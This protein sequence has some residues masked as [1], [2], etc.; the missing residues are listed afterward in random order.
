MSTTPTTTTTTTTVAL[1]SISPT[2]AVVAGYG[3]VFGG[4]DLAGESFAA[5][6]DFQLDLV[7]RKP[8]FYD[9]TLQSEL[10]HEIGEVLRIVPDEGGLWIE[11]QLDRRKHYVAQVLELVRQGALGY[12]S[13]SVPHLVRRNGERI[14]AWPLV[15]VSLTPTPAEPRSNVQAVISMGTGSDVYKVDVHKVYEEKEKQTM[16]NGTTTSATT[17]TAGAQQVPTPATATVLAQRGSGHTPTRPTA[18]NEK[19]DT[20]TLARLEQLEQQVRGL[21]EEPAIKAGGFVVPGE[22]AGGGFRS[23]A[24]A[25]Y[26]K[27]Y[28]SYIRHGR[29]VK[30]DELEEGESAEG[31]Y[32]V[33]THYS[34]DLVAALKDASILRAAGARVISMSG[35]NSFKVPRMT[36]GNAAQQTGEEAAFDTEGPAFEEVE[37]TPWKYTRLTKVSDELLADSRI[38]IMQQVLLPDFEVAFATAENEQFT[39][40]DGTTEPQGLTVGGTTVNTTTASTFDEEDVIKLF[41]ALPYLY[42]AS[43]VWFMNDAIARQVRLFRESG[44]SGK[45]I[46]EPSFQSGQPDRL[47][48]RPVYTLNNLSDTVSTGNAIMVFCDPRFFWVV[49][50]GR[51]TLRRLDELYAAS[52][53]VG[54]RAYRRI[55]SRVMMTEAV[56][57]LTVQ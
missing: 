39:N 4:R 48:G 25:R 13:G 31:G 54:F 45:F 32:L 56:Q 55:D 11:A 26:I 44:T 37:F 7:P 43:G 2:H 16:A 23:E 30:Y 33:P 49:D 21:V 40:G 35:T 12:S 27:A 46:W 5:D 8:V 42:R 1:K 3:V 51:E 34:N 24:E 41:H 9:H 52:G 20:A 29:A 47:L 18:A 14:K 57:V 22:S 6:C 36:H 17:T 38:D 19:P 53:Q 50:F 15:E 28:N 10:R